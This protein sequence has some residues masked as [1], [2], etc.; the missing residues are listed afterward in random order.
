MLLTI[1]ALERAEGVSQDEGVVI[2]E[3]GLFLGTFIGTPMVGGTL[4]PEEVPHLEG[5]GGFFWT[6]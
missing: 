4:A 6:P 5:G 3:L 1:G 2:G